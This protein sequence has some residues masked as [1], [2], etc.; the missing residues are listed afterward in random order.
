ARD[1]QIPVVGAGPDYVRV[2]WR[3]RYRIDRRV[4][5]GGG[6]VDCH[7]A[8]LLL[9][10]F[11]WIVGSEIRRDAIRR[12]PEVARAEEILRTDIHRPVASRT[13]V[14]G[15]VPVEAQL[16]FLVTRQRPDPARFMS[17]PVDAT[18][19][20]AL[21]LG[22]DVGRIGGIGEHPE[23][24][25]AVHVLPAAAGDSAGILRVADP[26]AVVLQATIDMVGTIVVEAHVVE[27]GDGQIISL[28]PLV[29]AVERIP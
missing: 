9:Q 24:V 18:D 26:R 20:A 4:H 21:I 2:F 8:R 19:L 10:L 29:A 25:A 5:F 28:P 13:D 1:L 23:S 16:F 14:D 22:V 6:V 12:L 17:L 7:T 27:L 3:F 15:S 11:G